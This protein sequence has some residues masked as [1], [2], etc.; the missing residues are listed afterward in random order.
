MVIS[1]VLNA[2]RIASISSQPFQ[3]GVRLLVIY[4]CLIL[5]DCKRNLQIGRHNL[6]YFSNE[7]DLDESFSESNGENDNK[8]GYREYLSESKENNEDQE[9]CEGNAFNYAF[10][11]SN[12]KV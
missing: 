5:L 4:Y 8:S 10:S 7:G 3:G 11:A 1:I 6:I 12:K 9:F 2:R